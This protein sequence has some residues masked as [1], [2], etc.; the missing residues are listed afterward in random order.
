M[1]ESLHGDHFGSDVSTRV[2]TA[3]ASFLS[4]KGC[5]HGK[6]VVR[7]LCQGLLPGLPRSL[8]GLRLRR[9]DQ[10]RGSL[11]RPLR[12][13]AIRSHPTRSSR[14]GPLARRSVRK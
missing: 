12:A 3:V 7:G 8:F 14:D 2:M 10:L 9:A 4:T 5:S 6:L 11:R 1:I 13:Y